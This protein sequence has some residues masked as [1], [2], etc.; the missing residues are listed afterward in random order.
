MDIVR[1]VADAPARRQRRGAPDDLPVARAGCWRC[2]RVAALVAFYVVLQLRRKA[3]RRAVHQRRAA[4][5][6]RAQAAGLAPAPGLRRRRARP[7][8]AGRV[9]GRAEHRGAGAAG[10]GDGDA[11]RSTS[12]C[13]CRPPTS[14]PTASAAM[15]AAAKE[16]VDVLPG[17]DQP[18]AGVVR[19]HGD[20]A[21]AADHRPGPGRA[22]RSTTCELAESTAIGEAIFTSLTAIENFQSTLDGREREAAAGPD[23]AAV[24]R[25]QHRRP[26]PDTQAVDAA[27]AAERAGLDDRVRHRLR[28]PRPRR[29]DRAGAGRPGRR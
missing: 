20:H 27:K 6:A 12:R 16:F 2:S 28:H 1:F 19:R 13:R 24:R 15:Q 3:L 7:G 22:A 18:G 5:L 23:R 14:S 25:L 21:R 10:A 9:A 8:R 17:A 29:R 11:W 4:R 26:R